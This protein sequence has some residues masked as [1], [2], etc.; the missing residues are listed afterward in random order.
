MSPDT[1]TLRTTKVTTWFERDRA[2][3]ALVTKDE[4]TT[5]VEWWDEDVGQAVEDGFLKM[6]DLHRTALEYWKTHVYCAP[7]PTRSPDKL[8]FVASRG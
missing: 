6:N 3:V 1:A 2:F 8:K 5:L 4:Q 7:S